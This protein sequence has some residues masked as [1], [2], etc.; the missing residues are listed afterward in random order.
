V[1]GPRSPDAPIPYDVDLVYNPTGPAA[2]V[3]GGAGNDVISGSGE[4]QT[5]QGGEGDDVAFGNG[6]DDLIDGGLG[7]D[8][9]IPGSGTDV[10]QAGDGNDTIDGL[11]FDEGQW[12]YTGKDPESGETFLADSFSCGAGDDWVIVDPVDRVSSDCEHVGTRGSCVQAAE[13]C[14]G[15][16]SITTGVAPASASGAA[17]ATNQTRL[18]KGRFK[19]KGGNLMN[20][21]ANLNSKAVRLVAAKGTVRA[22]AKVTCTARY[23]RRNDRTTVQKFKLTLVADPMAPGSTQTSPGKLARARCR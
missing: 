13:G 9:L 10:V 12:N 11:V 7:N 6:G 18:G 14:A 21:V 1:P 3:L 23:K 15:N 8:F 16:I 2:T 17:R 20:Q 22:T 4:V 5:L 19:A